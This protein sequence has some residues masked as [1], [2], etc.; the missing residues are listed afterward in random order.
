LVLSFPYW[1]NLADAGELI[2]FADLRVG[3][4]GVGK[5]L[6]GGG[7]AEVHVVCF[8]VRA[9]AGPL[10][11]IHKIGVA[12][13]GEVQPDGHHLVGDTVIDWSEIDGGIVGVSEDIGQ[14]RAVEG[15]EAGRCAEGADV[16]VPV[17]ES[18]GV[19]GEKKC[20]VGEDGVGEYVVGG[21]VEVGS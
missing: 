7:V 20:A 17:E 5:V 13:A 14:L 8:A 3:E 9:D 10:R 1:P 18:V 16:R 19:S 15:A 2:A 12:G 21:G 11:A 4:G 6:Y